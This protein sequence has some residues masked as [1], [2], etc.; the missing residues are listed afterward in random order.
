[1]AD[2]RIVDLTLQSTWTPAYVE[3]D[4]GTDSYKMSI[5]TLTSSVVSS[6][7]AADQL[8]NTSL[9][10]N[11]DSSIPTISGT[12]F[13]DAATSHRDAI[14]LLDTAIG[15][16][17]DYGGDNSYTNNYVVSDGTDHKT[18][19]SALDE[20]LENLNSTVGAI[21]A[22]TASV[23]AT[24]ITV[25]ITPAILNAIIGG[26]GTPYNIIDL[27]LGATGRRIKI[28]D[29][30]IDIDSKGSAHAATGSIHLCYSDTYSAAN[31]IVEIP[32]AVLNASADGYYDPV[33]NKGSLVTANTIDKDIYLVKETGTTITVGTT[34]LYLNLLYSS[35]SRDESIAPTE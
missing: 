32:S 6:Y 22:A 1:M 13:I 16:V 17:N 14:E 35:Y 3:I 33:V 25:K 8:Q 18:A 34:D 31:S 30:S 7:I 27:A 29:I 9:G 2:K 4:D 26:T 28:H 20:G 23:G 24:K 11:A 15:T 5:T 19:I 12:N 10:L 21:S